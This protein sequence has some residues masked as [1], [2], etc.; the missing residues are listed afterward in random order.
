MAF[1]LGTGPWLKVS[2]DSRDWL[3]AFEDSMMARLSEGSR[4]LRGEFERH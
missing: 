2:T 1:F 4:L 3:K